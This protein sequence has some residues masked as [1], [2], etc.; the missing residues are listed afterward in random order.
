[1]L[2]ITDPARPKV[3]SNP[4]LPDGAF[5]IATAA[6]YVPPFL[7]RFALVAGR[8]AIDAVNVSASDKPQ[9]LGPLFG[10]G[11]PVRGIALEEFALDRMV[12]ESGRQLKDISHPDARYLT[13]GEIDRVL[14][15][16]LDPRDYLEETPPPVTTPGPRNK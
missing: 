12:D 10:E 8:N 3:V 2:R 9:L 6:W 16:P 14:H 13:R 15:V 11:L 5:K 4:V 7:Q 1:M